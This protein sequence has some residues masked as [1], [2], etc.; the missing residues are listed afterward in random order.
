MN[1]TLC[2]QLAPLMPSLEEID[3][4]AQARFPD[5]EGKRNTFADGWVRGC[6]HSAR[7]M[8]M[9]GAGEP[10]EEDEDETHEHGE[11]VGVVDDE[12]VDLGGMPTQPKATDC[13][14]REVRMPC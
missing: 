13:T 11:P 14:R 2:R 8:V 12:A 6:Y 9:L 10:D 3:A 4:E 1:R 5:D 7:V